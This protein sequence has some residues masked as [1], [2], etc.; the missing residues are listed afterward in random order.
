VEVRFD[1]P[2]AEIWPQRV[3]DLYAGE[4]IVVAARLSKPNG[5][6]ILSGLI[7]K[8]EWHD[9]HTLSTTGEQSGIGRLWARR[10]IESLTD[11]VEASAENSDVKQQI[12]DLALE[13]HLVTPYTSLVAVDKTPSGVPLEKCETRAV[14]VNLPAG[15]G[16]LDGSLPKT[17]TTAPLFLLC[18]GLLLGLAALLAIRS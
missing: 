17:A 12:V 9:V 1:D 2:A 3:P 6:I 8:E 14:P 10:K 4:P 13:H 7:G 11:S 16:G 18:G 5:R 15:W